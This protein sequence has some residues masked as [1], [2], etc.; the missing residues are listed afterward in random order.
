[1]RRLLFACVIAA[2]ACTSTPATTTEPGQASEPTLAASN[3]VALQSVTTANSADGNRFVSGSGSFPR[4]P[5]TV[6]LAE[7]PAWLLAVPDGD[8]VVW[9]VVAESG[10]VSAFHRSQG[11]LVPRPVNLE[12]LPAGTP[13]AAAVGPAG[14]LLLAPPPPSASVFTNP[15]ALSD[16]GLAFVSADGS[17]VS[18]TGE[19]NRTFEIEA[20]PDSRLVTTDGLLAV[21]TGPTDRYAHGVLG[22]AIEAS[23]LTVLDP[24]R[25]TVEQVVE[26]EGSVVEGISPMWAD[27]DDDAV[28]ELV[29]TLSDSAGGARLAVVSESGAIAAESDPI[30]QASR[31]RHQIAAGPLGPNG[32]TELVEVVTPHLGGIVTFHRLDGSDLVEVASIGGFTSHE[33]GS[34]NLDMAIVADADGDGRFEVVI[35][36]QRRTELAGIQRTDDGAAVVW[37]VELEGEIVTNIAAADIGGSLVLAVGTDDGRLLVWD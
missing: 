9:V 29:V 11:E 26:F 35:P 20:L 1:M 28:A 17:V 3:G 15:I 10:T 5:E 36:N 4:E 25:Q 33:L 21:L 31:W 6:A 32:E 2:S 24:E 27:I 18:V 30:G 7:K 23:S 22:D 14:I 13:P 37:S 16:G 8:A 34:R 12:S 19:G